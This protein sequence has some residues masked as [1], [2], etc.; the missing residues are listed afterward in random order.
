MILQRK[1]KINRGVKGQIATVP[2]P[3]GGLN[4]RDSIA[5]M[6]A[7]DAVILD[8]WF[9]TPTNIVIR[10]GSSIHNDEPTDWV[11]SLFAYN[12]AVTK[13]LYAVADGEIREVTTSSTGAVAD[14]TG[15]TNSRWQY[16][17]YA[18]AGG[19]YIYCVNGADS[20]LLYN[21]TTWTSI[22]GVSTP[23]ITGVT[24]SDLI[25]VN[26]FKNRIWFTQ[27]SSTKVWYLPTNSIGGAATSIDFGPLFRLGGYLMGMV[28][29]T[30]N[31][32]SGTDD[33]AVFVSSEGEALV[34]KGYDPS[35]AATWGLVAS[36]RIGRPIGRRF[37]TKVGSDVVMITAD[38]AVMLSKSLLADRSSIKDALSDKITNLITSDV[39]M[40]NANFGWQPILYPIGNKLL[41]NVP[42]VENT[43]QY[44]Y[45]MNTITGAWCSFGKVNNT[46]SWN[47]ACFEIFND[48]LYYGGENGVWLCDS[49]YGDDGANVAATAKPAFNYFKNRGLQKLFTMIKPYFQSN[50]AVTALIGINLDF[51]DADPVSSVPVSPGGSTSLWDVSYWNVSYWGSSDTITKNWQT[52]T[53]IGAAAT[54]KITV[55][56]NQQL[57]L[58]SI[59]YVYEAGGIL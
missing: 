41:V 4:A 6:P 44:Q 21:G 2:A 8:N 16:I 22:T 23:A 26:I 35:S 24:T 40:Y 28:T 43:A 10:N 25:H 33:Y 31:D 20:A 1:K 14:V 58:Q 53:G 3:V 34:Y 27:E 13:E 52:V 32:S 57:S 37:Y 9:P 18:T 19:N 38:G 48:S 55:F 39:Q 29:W 11:E 7:T 56:T 47:A 30:I 50:A 51:S 45:V 15:L 36:F 42:R 46:S 17:N 12:G 59:D 5:N 49:G 54:T